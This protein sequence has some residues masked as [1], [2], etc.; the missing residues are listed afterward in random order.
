MLAWPPRNACCGPFHPRAVPLVARADGQE[1]VGVGEGEHLRGTTR[2]HA[3]S[4][5]SGCPCCIAMH[6]RN[7]PK[8]AAPC[9]CAG[10]G[11]RG[12]PTP[13]LG[14]R[15]AYLASR[16]H[17]QPHAVVGL[18]QADKAAGGCRGSGGEARGIR[19]CMVCSQGLTTKT[20][21][22]RVQASSLT[23]SAPHGDSPITQAGTV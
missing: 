8:R 12:R 22:S 5:A 20:A 6:M 13:G 1:G 9:R 11:P 10:P 3:G 15:G 19:A 4:H 7:E 23:G 2:L 14:E 21:P 18:Y 17:G 16:H